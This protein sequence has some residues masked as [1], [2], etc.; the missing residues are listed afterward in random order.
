MRATASSPSIAAIKAMAILA[1]GC[2]IGASDGGG[3]S[4]CKGL[5]SVSG[6]CTGLYLGTT[7]IMYKLFSLDW[8]C[9]QKPAVAFCKSNA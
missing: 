8:F 2:G 9:S 3:G 1:M 6:L 4:G 5:S 7:T